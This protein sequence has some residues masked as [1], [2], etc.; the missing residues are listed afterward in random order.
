MQGPLAGVVVLDL[1]RLLPGPYATQVMADLG[2]R[3]IKVEEPR[4]GDYLRN[5]PPMAGDHSA[6]F[7][8]LNR[9]KQSIALDLKA[10]DDVETF[11]ALVRQSHVVVE[12]FRPGVMD[13]LGLGYAALKAI[14]PRV[15]VCSISGYG[16][17]GPDAL[18]AGHDLNYMA[19]A[20]VL[21]Y[22]LSLIH[23]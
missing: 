11:R 17:Q 21:G 9:G 10:P 7:L 5:M 8:A 18:R 6:L 2:A 14:N 3:V 1:S 13:K 22:G 15:V 12:S 20:G 23:I 19:R 4:G 16:Q